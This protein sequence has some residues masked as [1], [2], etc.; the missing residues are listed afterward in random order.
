MF[1]SKPLAHEWVFFHARSPVLFDLYRFAYVQPC[2]FALHRCY[3]LWCTCE[4]LEG[5]VSFH[6]CSQQCLH[7]SW[8]WCLYNASKLILR[9]AIYSKNMYNVCLRHNAMLVWPEV[10]IRLTD[11]WFTSVQL[12]RCHLLPALR[13]T[14]EPNAYC[15]LLTLNNGLEQTIH[16]ARV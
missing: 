12:D 16:E 13:R 15:L 3:D 1:R 7:W 8:R 6:S 14:S 4:L 2:I 11:R 5:F 9:L 10:Y